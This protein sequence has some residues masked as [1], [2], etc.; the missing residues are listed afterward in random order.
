MLAAAL[1]LVLMAA[2]LAFANFRLIWT[3]P[4]SEFDRNRRRLPG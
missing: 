3:V 4:Q 2:D 1:A